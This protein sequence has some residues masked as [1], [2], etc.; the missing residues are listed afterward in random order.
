M[1]QP[2]S[3]E[4]IEALGK[5]KNNTAPGKNDILPE[6]VRGCGGEILTHIMDLFST[7]WREERVPAEWRDAILVPIPKKGDQSKCGNW[8]GSVYLTPWGS[9]SLKLSR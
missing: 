9:F 2:P 3:E 5:L 1:A 4:V 6:M 7:V 8:R